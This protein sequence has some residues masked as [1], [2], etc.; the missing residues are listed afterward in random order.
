MERCA[1]R[2]RLVE[3]YLGRLNLDTS[4]YRYYDGK[5]ILVTGG[6]GAIG[7][8]LII[9]LS[10]L[11]GSTGK[12]VVL[13]NLS[14]IK[15]ADPWNVAPLPNIMFVKGDVRNDTDLKRVFKESPSIVFHL[16]V[17]RAP[18]PLKVALSYPLG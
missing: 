8:N 15:V 18:F 14:S 12:V 4:I 13:D 17:H 6:A 16:A 5:T 1:K 10:R 7:S 3:D 9:A 2:V 11:V